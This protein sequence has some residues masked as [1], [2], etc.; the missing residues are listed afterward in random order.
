MSAGQRLLVPLVENTTIPE[1]FP[2]DHLA[3]ARRVPNDRWTDIGYIDDV[4]PGPVFRD[5]FDIQSFV[6]VIDLRRV[7][8][9]SFRC[10]SDSAE[11]PRRIGIHCILQSYLVPR[12]KLLALIVKRRIIGQAAKFV[13]PINQ[14]LLLNISD[15]VQRDP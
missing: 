15:S 7:F 13:P 2:I 6:V 14:L 1:A 5:D 10:D 12:P 8:N 3:V 11:L 9:S 4:L